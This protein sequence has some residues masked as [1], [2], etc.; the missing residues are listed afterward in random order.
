MKVRSTLLLVAMAATLVPMT[1]GAT[2][3][4][5]PIYIFSTTRVQT[6]IDDPTNPEQK[7]GRG[8]PSAVSSVVGCTVV[9]DTVIAEEPPPEAHA[10]TDSD[11]VYPNSNRMSVR[12]LDNG[13]DP[14]IIESATLEWAGQTIDLTMAQT[15]DVTGAPAAF[16]DSQTIVIDPNDTLAANTA[17]ATICL[18]GG[19]CYTRTYR[20]IVA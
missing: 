9:R 12:L 20:T 11:I 8:V 2:H 15:V 5:N 6:D 3:C 18:T 14:S 1:A 10:V 16:L 17:T 7:I 13:N 19:T 4:S